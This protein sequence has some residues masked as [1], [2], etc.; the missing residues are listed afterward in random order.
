MTQIP[1][2]TTSLWV[3]VTDGHPEAETPWRP[4]VHVLLLSLLASLAFSLPKLHLAWRIVNTTNQVELFNQA[5]ALSLATSG[6]RLQPK[7]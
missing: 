6:E 3:P 7:S 4:P 1:T 2:A 5:V